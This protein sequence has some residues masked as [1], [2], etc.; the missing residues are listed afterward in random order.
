MTLPG[1][2]DVPI[3]H[4]DMDAFFASVEV[5][6]DPTLR[7][8]PV[9]VGG[10]GAR[11]VV[12]SASYEARVFGVRSAMPSARARRLC[13]DAVFVSGRFDRYSEVST[14]LRG[15]LVD[16]TPLVEPVGLDEAFLDISGAHL[17]PREIAQRI[18]AR[19]ETELRLSCSVGAGRTKLVAKLASRAAKPRVADGLRPGPGVVIVTAEQ[20]PGFLLPLPVRAIWGVGP[21][22]A[23]RLET[24]GVRTIAELAELPEAALVRRFG[25]VQGAL[26]FHLARGEDPRRVEPDRAPKSIGNET[27]FPQD[28][29]DRVALGRKIASL[30]EAVSSHLRRSGLVAKTVQLKVRY[31]DFT[32]L[33]RRRSVPVPLD[34]AQSIGEIARSLLDALGVEEGVRLLGVSVSGLIPAGAPRQEALDLGAGSGSTPDASVARAAALQRTW[35]G[36]AGTVDELRERFGPSAV[37]MGSMVG[38]EGISVPRRHGAPWGP[39]D[40]HAAQERTEGTGPEG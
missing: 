5:L 33:T 34:T 8:R 13:P 12:A 18:R 6:D 3:L 35:E 20:E 1:P 26:L 28:I 32:T 36:L 39:S 27:T 38:P 25:A 23:A 24:L 22:A 9:I 19:V 4:V 17:G 37:G 40:G 2:G 30:S 16:E 10:A 7:G 11:G 15:V 14:Q 31:G 29:S 21:T